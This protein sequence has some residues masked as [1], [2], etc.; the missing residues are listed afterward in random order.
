MCDVDAIFCR[1]AGVG[2]VFHTYIPPALNCFVAVSSLG[3][4]GLCLTERGDVDTLKIHPNFRLFAAMNPP[5]D[6][7]KKE[8]PSALRNRFTEVRRRSGRPLRFPNAPLH[9]AVCCGC[10]S[11]Y[12]RVGPTIVAHRCPDGTNPFWQ[13]F[14]EDVTD[15]D[16]LLTIAAQQLS[17]VPPGA[18]IDDVVGFYLRARELAR[19][20]QRLVQKPVGCTVTL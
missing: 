11:L 15:R 19:V 10:N 8:L 9:G 7:G 20:R 12:G 2:C 14:V 4:G 16:D 3:D 5:T 6:V 17:D 13:V 18:P 1:I